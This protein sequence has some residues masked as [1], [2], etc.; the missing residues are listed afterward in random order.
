MKTLLAKIDGLKTYAFIGIGL[1]ATLLPE[2]QTYVTIAPKVLL[3]VK[4][5]AG[6]AA[7]YGR[8]DASR[9]ISDALARGKDLGKAAMNDNS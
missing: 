7:I 9:K 5:C 2:V 8:L 6:L 1:I 4:V 3:T